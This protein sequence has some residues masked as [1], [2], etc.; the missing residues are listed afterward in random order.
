VWRSAT[1][2]SCVAVTF[3]GTILTTASGLYFRS[4]E[5]RSS[6]AVTRSLSLSAERTHTVFC[7]FPWYVLKE[8]CRLV[9]VEH[10]VDA[11]LHHEL[12]VALVCLLHDFLRR[13]RLHLSTPGAAPRR[14][15]SGSTTTMYSKRSCV[16]SQS[17]QDV[18]GSQ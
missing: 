14:S 16:G 3:E 11:K 1:F 10:N 13:L 17:Y 6:I 8:Y 12:I 4:C 7:P 9:R 15:Q 2:S 18:I 5:S